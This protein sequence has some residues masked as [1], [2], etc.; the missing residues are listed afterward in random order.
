MG[1]PL[2]LPPFELPPLELPPFELPPFELPPLELPPFEITPL[3]SPAS[4]FIDGEGSP[5]PG[6]PHSQ[7]SK[8]PWVLQ[9]CTPSSDPRQAQNCVVPGVQWGTP[10]LRD[11][12][13]QPMIA[14]EHKIATRMV[15]FTP[16]R[17]S[18]P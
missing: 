18:H 6:M 17:I 5:S 8:V 14:N 1:S 3:L 2:E 16:S 10:P 7:S 12:L 9:V 15:V 11:L 13:L 4:A